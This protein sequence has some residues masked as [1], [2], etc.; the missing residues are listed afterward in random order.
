MSSVVGWLV[1]STSYQYAN[2]W[3]EQSREATKVRERGLLKFKSAG[4]AQRFVTAHAAVYNLFSIGR[5]MV[6]ILLARQG[7]RCRV[8]CGAKEK[9][10]SRQQTFDGLCGQEG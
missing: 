6:S 5:H 9:H 4:F 3:A 1:L 7:S 8:G 10:A 2:N